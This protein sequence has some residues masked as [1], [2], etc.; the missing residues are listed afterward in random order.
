MLVKVILKL[1]CG[2]A[3]AEIIEKFGRHLRPFFKV[4]RTFLRSFL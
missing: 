4:F 1:A 2:Q 3:E